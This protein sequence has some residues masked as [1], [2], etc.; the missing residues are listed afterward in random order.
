M[1]VEG[2]G[3]RGSGFRGWGSGF[4]GCLEVGGSGSLG[5]SCWGGGS[6]CGAGRS[7]F[8]GLAVDDWQ[9]YGDSDCGLLA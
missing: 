9:C 7:G 4:R 2:L 8:E 1:W 6:R 5:F 3:C